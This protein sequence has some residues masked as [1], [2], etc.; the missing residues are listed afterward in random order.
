MPMALYKTIA[1]L[2]GDSG[3]LVS[4]RAAKTLVRVS[5][6]SFLLL[7]VTPLHITVLRESIL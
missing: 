5:P 1:C 3:G 6:K 2:F 7:K 4:I